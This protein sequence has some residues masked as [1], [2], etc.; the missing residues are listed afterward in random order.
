MLLESL[1]YIISLPAT[2]AAQRPLLFDAVGLW[3]RG[4]RQKKAWAVH[5]SRTRAAIQAATKA[6]PSRRTV[7]VLGSGPLFDVP[8][9]TLSET[10]ERVILVDHIH[11][12]PARLEIRKFANVSMAWHDLS[13]ATHPDPLGF[14]ADLPDLDCVISVNLLSQLAQG[15]PEGRERAVIDAHLDGLARLAS[16]VIVVTDTAYR[17]FDNAGRII[18]DFDAL[19]GRQMPESKNRWVW[20][21]APYGEEAS[22]TRRV[23]SVASYPDWKKALAGQ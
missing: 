7:V 16:P 4:R 18:E 2:P 23:H 22:G 1:V 13:I 20:N 10:F 9:R 14:L 19:Y 6:L 5:T 3:A 11:L 17:M 12:A 21:L 15:A 8:V